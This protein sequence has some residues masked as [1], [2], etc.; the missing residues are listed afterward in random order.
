MI[1]QVERQFLLLLTLAVVGISSKQGEKESG[2]Q[3]AG[4]EDSLNSV[5]QKG[6]GKE[7]E[8]C[9]RVDLAS[10]LGFHGGLGFGWHLVREEEREGKCP[11]TREKV[12]EY[13]DMATGDQRTVVTQMLN[14]KD[15]VYTSDSV[16]GLQHR[17]TIRPE[18]NCL[19]QDDK[20]LLQE[21]RKH[22]LV[23][24]STKEGYNSSLISEDPGESFGENGQDAFLDQFLFKG[25]VKN[26][27][28]VEAGAD[29]F[30]TGTNSLMFERGRGWSG[31]LVEPHPLIFA[32]GLQVQ[33][34]AWS[35]ATCLALGTKPHLAK[36]ASEASPGAMAGLVP[37]DSP[38]NGTIELQ[39]LPMASLLLAMGNP[40]VNYLSLDLEGA[41]LEVIKTIPF[42]Q[43]N[44]EVLSV[45]FNLL[46][47][48]FPGSRSLLHSHLD[49]AGYSYVGTLGDKDDLFAQSQLLESKYKFSKEEV[50]EEEWPEFSFW[51]PA[52]SKVERN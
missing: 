17:V 6:I 41:E 1:G 40:T 12:E 20:S 19:D 31:L 18:L 47:R 16:P 51:D 46:G 3:T 22:Y 5:P 21:I 49:Q 24:P 33:R 50:L 4:T 43:L 26:G 36:F 10:Q 34:K 8:M 52:A 48:V 25:K 27:F 7:E 14:H 23:K 11:G 38:V 15:T 44:I 13:K 28:F 35:V 39:C 29:D 42:K 45:E 37:Q 32:K 2:G 30:V 9:E